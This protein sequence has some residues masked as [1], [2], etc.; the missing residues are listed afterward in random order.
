MPAQSFNFTD[1]YK[2]DVLSQNKSIF[3]DYADRI[4]PTELKIKDIT[5]TARSASYLVLN[6]ES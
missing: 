2:D 1:H 5:D 6:L 3:G 4:Y